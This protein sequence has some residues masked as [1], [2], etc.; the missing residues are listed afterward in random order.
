V[1]A[2]F[3]QRTRPFGFWSRARGQLEDA[4][5]QDIRAESR[6]DILGILLA[7]P[8]QL[9]LFMT[10]MIFVTQEWDKFARMFA[11]LVALSVGLYFVWF[12]HLSR[13][14]MGLSPAPAGE[15]N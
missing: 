9:V 13:K 12:R 15:S 7:V 11:I 3:F 5:V 2:D 8:W 6:R 4:V 1:L 14:G 10:A